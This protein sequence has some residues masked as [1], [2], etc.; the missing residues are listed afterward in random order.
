MPLVTG[1]I[2][3]ISGGRQTI[4]GKTFLERKRGIVEKKSASR[5]LKARKSS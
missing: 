1:E 2:R 3:K 5:D 4:F